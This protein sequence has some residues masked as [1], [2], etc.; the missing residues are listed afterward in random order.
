M[1]K[2][3]AIPVYFSRKT[4]DNWTRFWES[5]DDEPPMDL[6]ESFAK[7]EAVGRDELATWD[8]ELAD[9]VSAYTHRQIPGFAFIA[10][11]FGGYVQV[12]TWTP[13]H[14]SKGDPAFEWKPKKKAATTADVP[15]TKPADGDALTKNV[16]HLLRVVQ[17]LDSRIST[18]EGK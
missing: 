17:E 18:L 11:I 5:L 1:P 7:A 15:K 9:G 14:G 10:K 6:R 2:L 8:I 3:G 4:Q 16:Q 13:I 12:V